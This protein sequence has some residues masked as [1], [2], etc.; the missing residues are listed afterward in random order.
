MGRSLECWQNRGQ[1]CTSSFYC[2]GG[3][4]HR[5]LLK[6]TA[7]HNSQK[8]IKTISNLC[9]RYLKEH[10]E[11]CSVRCTACL[12]SL[13]LLLNTDSPS[14]L[15]CLSPHILNLSPHQRHTNARSLHSVCFSYWPSRAPGGE[16]GN[17]TSCVFF[18]QLVWFGRSSQRTETYKAAP[19]LVIK[20]N[21]SWI[22][23]H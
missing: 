9:R 23:L 18:R 2:E 5:T 1:S 21:T 4:I 14:K 6:L 12:G 22:K 19:R 20:H 3:R 17:F 13:P 15:L 11:W 10:T 7:I 16:W 8:L